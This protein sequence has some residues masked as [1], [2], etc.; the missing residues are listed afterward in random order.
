MKVCVC[1]C[2]CLSVAEVQG[3]VYALLSIRVK[4]LERSG[5][6]QC[7][8]TPQYYYSSHLSPETSLSFSLSPKVRTDTLFIQNI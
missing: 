7:V 3:H 8:I 6:G 4:I 2:C 1:M 5:T